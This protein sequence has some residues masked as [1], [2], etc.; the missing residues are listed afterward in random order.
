MPKDDPRDQPD[1]NEEEPTREVRRILREQ[2]ERARQETG[3]AAQRKLGEQFQAYRNR[4][5]VPRPYAVQRPP[6]ETGRED[7]RPMGFDPERMTRGERAAIVGEDLFNVT[8]VVIGGADASDVSASSRRVEFVVPL[9][10]EPDGE[11]A[12]YWDFGNPYAPLAADLEV[13][14]PDVRPEPEDY[15]D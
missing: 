9:E 14:L 3:D 12:V 4:S 5:P 6:F 11:T 7:P 8:R 10:A 1:N 2:D 13:E 15:G